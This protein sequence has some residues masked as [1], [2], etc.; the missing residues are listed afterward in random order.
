MS[1]DQSSGREE[2]REKAV[3]RKDQLILRGCHMDTVR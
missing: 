3:G 1:L 2:N